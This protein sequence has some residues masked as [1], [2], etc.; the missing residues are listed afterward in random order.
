MENL[1]DIDTKDRI[2][3]QLM[4]LLGKTLSDPDVGPKM[5]TLLEATDL[6]V[7]DLEQA[8]L[9][10]TLSKSEFDFGN[11]H[12]QS[13]ASRLT[14]HFHNVVE[15]S[16]H[17]NRH[18]LV[19]SF[20]EEASPE[21]I[22]DVGYGVPNPYIFSYLNKNPKAKARLLDMYASA[23]KF[24]EIL[25]QAEDPKLSSRI[26]FKI[27][28]MDSGEFP[29]DADTYLFLDSIEHTKKPIEYLKMLLEKSSPED[30]FIFSLPISTKSPNS[31]H[32]A[33]WL[34]DYDAR[35]WLENAGLE[36]LKDGIVHTNPSVDFFAELKK[37]G[38]HNYIALTKKT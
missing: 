2:Q 1:K 36:V 11:S 17:H 33:E 16:Y 23:E 10:H 37:G 27:Y 35:T 8:V 3:N 32:Y 38:F 5:H 4:G 12:Y 6:S 25:I 28:D 31:F 20:L 13:L 24:G 19:Y 26:E 7:N 14:L 34:T 30:N 29:G 22:I 18:Q 9:S 15:G 21:K